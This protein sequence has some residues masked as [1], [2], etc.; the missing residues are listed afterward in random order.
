[1]KKQDLKELWGE[2]L[3]NAFAD[4]ID[5]DGWLT[6]NWAPILEENYSD[7]DKDYN[8]TGEKSN[9]Y[10]RMYI[11]DFEKK[12]ADLGIFIRPI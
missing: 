4:H 11:Q 8:D 10:S 5:N 1:M 3:F 9:L 12:E 6:E 7:W 2:E